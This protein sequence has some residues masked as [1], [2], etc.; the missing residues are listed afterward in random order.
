MAQKKVY[1]ARK[2]TQFTLPRDP[3]ALLSYVRAILTARLNQ[4]KG[5]GPKKRVE[6]IERAI[7]LAAELS[8][9]ARADDVLGIPLGMFT[10]GYELGWIDKR[11]S[12]TRPALNKKALKDASRLQLR[13]QYID[14]AR[15]LLATNPT[16]SRRKL[17]TETIKAIT[18]FCRDFDISDKGIFKHSSVYKM[19]G[20]LMPSAQH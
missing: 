5:R 10:L 4:A 18:A 2:P 7:R 14:T 12:S 19:I 15:S 6:E 16:I 9:A 13:Q 11:R 1:P 8:V 17:A 3:Q 20:F